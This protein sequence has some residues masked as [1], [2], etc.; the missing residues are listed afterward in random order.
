M[1]AARQGGLGKWL[2]GI[3]RG[4]LGGKA[5]AAEAPAA[6]TEP[7]APVTPAIGTPPPPPT[8]PATGLTATPAVYR[9]G[10]GA[11]GARADRLATLK[12]AA[13]GSALGMMT[14]VEST[15]SGD[16]LVM[17]TSY[18]PGGD[19]P[20]STPASMKGNAALAFQGAATALGLATGVPAGS[21]MSGALQ[22]A[23]EAERGG[24]IGLGGVV[25]SAVPG[26]GMLEMMKKDAEQG[27]PI[28]SYLRGM[29]GIPDPGEPAP[30]QRGAGGA[31]ATAQL[32]ASYGGDTSGFDWGGATP[33]A[34]G[35]S[36][37][38]AAAESLRQDIHGLSIGSVPSTSYGVA[39]RTAP[40]PTGGDTAT[41]A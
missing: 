24:G 19:S 29:L 16:A 11:E 20:V 32:T 14:D 17:K 12:A 35:N 39:P 31:E 38:S 8:V 25:R 2:G 21:A 10:G 34:W 1:D 40:K 28:R 3:G 30:W 13:T 41:E 15:P 4:G 5:V 33:E 26:M 22:G 37:G 7:P 9:G 36:F 6:G 18:T 27:H 23:T